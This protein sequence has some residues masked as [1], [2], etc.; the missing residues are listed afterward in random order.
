[1]RLAFLKRIAALGLVCLIGQT[2][3]TFAEEPSTASPQTA[4]AAALVSEVKDSLHGFGA[5]FAKKDAPALG[6]YWTEDATYTDSDSQISLRGR[7]EIEAH[8]AALFDELPKATLQADITY[9]AD[10]GENLALIRGTATLISGDETTPSSFVAELKKVDGRWLLAAVE[11][12]PPDPLDNLDWLVGAWQDDIEDR[13]VT[14]E[15][16]WDESGRFLIRSFRIQQ[17][18]ETEKTGTEYIAWDASRQEIRSW[19]FNSEGSIGEGHWTMTEQRWSIHWTITL[20]GGS[21]ATATQS[22]T[23]I[24]LDSYQVAW[25]AIDVDGEMRPSIEPVTVLRVKDDIP[26]AIEESPSE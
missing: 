5:A 14:S 13:L 3:F 23:P 4:N 16:T 11:E 1:M 7:A 9:V 15:V 24:D 26:L 19:A 20:P 25:S 21:L 22:I 10:D 12:T 6:L 2:E 18:D 17:S 8:Y